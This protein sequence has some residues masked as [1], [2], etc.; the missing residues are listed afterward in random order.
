MVTETKKKYHFYY[1]HRNHTLEKSNKCRRLHGH[2]GKFVITFS[3]SVDPATGIGLLFNDI[4]V[5]VQPVLNFYDHYTIVSESDPKAEVLK[6]NFDVRIV[7]FITSAE[8][9]AAHIVDMI[10]KSISNLYFGT[11]KYAPKVSEIQFQETESST[12]ILKFPINE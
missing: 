1:G 3:S 9:V 11:S 10:N 6:N 7:T 4:D 8:N 2:V 5:I 12:V